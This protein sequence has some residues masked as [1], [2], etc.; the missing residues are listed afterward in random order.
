[1]DKAVCNTPVCISVSYLKQSNL[2]T[3]RLDE[4]R[5]MQG[6]RALAHHTQMLK[7]RFSASHTDAEGY[8]V[9][10]DEM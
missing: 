1:M 4:T 6:V 3:L 10:L 8:L 5:G 7:G 9:C 2:D